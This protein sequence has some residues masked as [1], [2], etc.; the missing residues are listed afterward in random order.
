MTEKHYGRRFN[1]N[2]ATANNNIWGYQ[3]LMYR[4]LQDRPQNEDRIR[5][6]MYD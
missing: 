4:T 5:G 6:M 3:S 1:S 2:I